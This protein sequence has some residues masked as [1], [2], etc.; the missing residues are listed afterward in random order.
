MPPYEPPA[1]LHYLP[2]LIVLPILYFRMRRMGKPQPLKLKRL[3]IRPVLLLVAACL[4][5]FLPQ[6]GQGAA[7]PLSP[8]EW[9]GLALT[10]LLGAGAG[11]QWGRTMHIEMHPEDGALMVKGGQAAML[12]LVLLLVVRMA[13][14]TGLEMEAAAWHLNLV[15]ITDAFILFSVALFSMRSL[16]MF[17]RARRVMAAHDA[18]PVP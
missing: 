3:W 2:L 12:L 6:P 4:V 14:R 17:L 10:A 18:K 15:M 7:P 13:L 8:L 1:Y 16:E 9:V 11:W 5:L